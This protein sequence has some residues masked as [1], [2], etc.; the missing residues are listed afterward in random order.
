MI[1]FVGNNTFLERIVILSKR[2][3]GT[4]ACPR[5]VAYLCG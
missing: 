2:E 1:G 3:M 5:V 4:I